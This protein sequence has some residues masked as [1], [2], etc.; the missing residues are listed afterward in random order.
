MSKS[1]RIVT[2]H[3]GARYFNEM[4]N[5]A[6]ELAERAGHTLEIIQTTG[7]KHKKASLMEVVFSEEWVVWMDTDSMLMGNID[8]L[9]ELDCDLILCVKEPENRSGRYGSYLYSG[10]VCVHNT[11]A[12]REF[13]K[14]WRE[15]PTDQP[16]DQLNL[17][18]VLEEYLDDSVYDQIGTTQVY[19]ELRV[20][21]LDPD[22]YYHQKSIHKMIPPAIGT[23]ALHFKGRLHRKWLEYKGFLC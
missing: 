14:S 6:K 9:F 13:L 20:H 23:K 15:S 12:G 5:V 4:A 2:A 21:F 17:H 8:H 3:D 18:R 22:V 19:G 10:F 7:V 1:V 11:S 16:S